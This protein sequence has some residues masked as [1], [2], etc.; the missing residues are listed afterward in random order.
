LAGWVKGLEGNH[1]EAI[2]LLLEGLGEKTDILPDPDSTTQSEI[3]TTL[4]GFL[5]ESGNAEEA[6]T[7]L[8]E[9]TQDESAGALAHYLAG[10]AYHQTGDAYQCAKSYKQ[11]LQIDENL[12]SPNDYLVYAWAEDKLN[13]PKRSDSIL[14]K[15]IERFPMEP[16]L[17]FNRAANHEVM[18]SSREAF[19]DYQMEMLVGGEG[20]AFSEEAQKRINK[21]LSIQAKLPSPDKDLMNV[22]FYIKAHEQLANIDPAQ[23]EDEAALKKQYERMDSYLDKVLEGVREPHPFLIYL[24]AQRLMEKESYDQAANWLEKATKDF[25]G[26][27]LFE[28]KLAQV[29]AKQGKQEKSEKL[30]REAQLAA[31]DHWIVRETLGPNQTQLTEQGLGADF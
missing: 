2:D 1:K 7:Y 20:S 5:I 18:G 30:I 17:Y 13:R 23:F 21:I 29:Y 3:K 28:M 9:L 26:Q 25:P 4:A 11:A 31:P 8:K 27:V 10:L 19:Y 14:D 16:G 6:V 15:G 12:A 22:A 24:K